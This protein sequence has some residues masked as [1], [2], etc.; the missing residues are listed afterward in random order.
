MKKIALLFLVLLISGCTQMSTDQDMEMQHDHELQHNNSEGMTHDHSE[1]IDLPSH[2]NLP[3]ISLRVTEDAHSGWN[4][5]I[6]TQNFRF[7]P[8]NASTEH[9]EGEGHAHLYID[10]KK[11]S[12]VYGE[13]THIDNLSPGRHK[14]KVS[15]N[16]NNH[17]P[18]LHD[19]MEIF[20]FV[21]IDQK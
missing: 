2:E 14:V 9:I 8:E 13:W 6:L 18:F 11:I 5:R 1:G 3:A 7:A 10:N 20:D 21:W 4:V 15:L 16:A 19:G 17:S 12:R